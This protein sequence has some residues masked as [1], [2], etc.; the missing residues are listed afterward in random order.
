MSVRVYRRWG[1]V[2][3]GILVTWRMWRDDKAARAHQVETTSRFQDNVREECMKVHSKEVTCIQAYLLVITVWE[4]QDG[5]NTAL[6]NTPK[7][8]EYG[9]LSKSGPSLIWT[10]CLLDRL[11][12]SFLT[13]RLSGRSWALC[14][15][16][17]CTATAPQRDSVPP[18]RCSPLSAAPRRTATARQ[19][20]E[21]QG[22]EFSLKDAPVV[23]HLDSMMYPLWNISFS[24]VPPNQHKACW[25]ELLFV[26]H[27]VVSSVSD[28]ISNIY[29][30]VH[31]LTLVYIIEYNKMLK[32]FLMDPNFIYI[33]I[34][35]YMYIYVYIYICIC[36]YIC[37]YI[38]YIQFSL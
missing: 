17:E 35:I 28:F 34:Y 36:I 12:I 14:P 5:A 33:Y 22:K 15:G 19:T 4:R 9:H 37:I 23:L 24:Q 1:K 13:W 8:E 29:N 2:W 21:L 38:K 7:K 25:V 26:I 3:N 16:S 11:N 32:D 6:K 27:I 30:S 31:E 10:R 20:E 18:C